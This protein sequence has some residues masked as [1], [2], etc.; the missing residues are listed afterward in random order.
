MNSVLISAIMA[1]TLFF[2][3]IALLEIG[4]RLGNRRLA[5]DRE[6]GR[7]GAGAIEGAIFALLGLLIAFTFS[8]AASRYETRRHLVVEEANAVGTAWLR[9][10][11]LPEGDRSQLQELFRQYLD[12]RLEAY[13][14]LPDLEAAY[15]EL[16][17]STKLQGE[18]WRRAVASSQTGEGERARMLLLPAL[19]EMIDIT[20]IRTMS[21]KAHPPTII[22]ALLFVLGMGCAFLAGYGMA[23]AKERSWAHIIGFA[24]VMA[25]TFYVILDIEF[26][27]IGLIRVDAADQVLL[28][29]RE[30]MK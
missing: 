15:A 30:S 1:L 10:D 24:A 19:N 22:F 8:G 28:E 17:H 14:K 27:R 21:A 6:G 2:G 20:T 13:G 4:R 7:A 11:L 25:I 29:L 18:I 9:L 12:S 3:M 26:P 5:K 23:G 16:E